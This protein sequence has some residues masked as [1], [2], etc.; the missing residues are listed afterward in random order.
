MGTC[1]MGNIVFS[2]WKYS[3]QSMRTVSPRSLKIQHMQ[4]YKTAKQMGPF[5]L[6]SPDHSTLQH[7]AKVGFLGTGLP[8]GAGYLPD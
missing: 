1:Q 5:C 6:P 8:V 3:T 4:P 2:F 7:C